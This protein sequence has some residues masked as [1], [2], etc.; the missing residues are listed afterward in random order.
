MAGRCHEVKVIATLVFTLINRDTRLI[1]IQHTF[2][3]DGSIC[4]FASG[5]NLDHVN[6]LNFFKWFTPQATEASSFCVAIKYN[7]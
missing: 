6:L 3:P 1:H 4:A 2:M 7:Y 5:F